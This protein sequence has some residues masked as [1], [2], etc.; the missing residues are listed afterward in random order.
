[1]NKN[2]KI[3]VHNNLGQKILLNFKYCKIIEIFD[4][5]VIL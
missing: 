2:K 5:L 1:M 4:D 3:L